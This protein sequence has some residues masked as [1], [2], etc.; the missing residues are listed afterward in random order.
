M[1]KNDPLVPHTSCGLGILNGSGQIIYS[2]MI[3]DQPSSIA[4]PSSAKDSSSST[5]HRY[6]KR[7]EL[8]GT[9]IPDQM[10]YVGAH[11]LELESRRTRF[12][13]LANF[14][15]VKVRLPKPVKLISSNTCL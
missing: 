10:G 12:R 6:C 7:E 3:L 4:Q 13:I 14:Q 9:L 11:S 1:D 2:N 8:R 15:Q 5:D